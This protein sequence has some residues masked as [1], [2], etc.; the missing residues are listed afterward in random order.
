MGLGRDFFFCFALHGKERV[1]LEAL[2]Q[3]R[4]FHCI[5]VHR[6]HLGQAVL[7][8]GQGAAC[9][10]QAG[11]QNQHGLAQRRAAGRLA[12]QL[13]LHPPL[14]RLGGHRM[15]RIEGELLLLIVSEQ[16]FEFNL[17]RDNLL[18]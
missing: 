14:D 13:S 3:R 5:L 10:H 4:F 1:G 7:G 17:H 9:Q 16:F 6:L 12:S 8:V 11:G 2:E 18:R 15:G